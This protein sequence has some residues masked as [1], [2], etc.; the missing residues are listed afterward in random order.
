MR[1]PPPL[2]DEPPPKVSITDIG[3]TIGKSEDEN[4]FH[5]NNEPQ[6]NIQNQVNPMN[7]GHPNQI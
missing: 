2:L 7:Y 4:R 5:L 1:F 6:G 3:K